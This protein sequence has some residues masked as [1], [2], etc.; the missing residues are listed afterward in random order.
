M[1]NMN[2]DNFGLVSG[3]LVSDP[4]ILSNSNGSRK[5]RLTLA[6]QNNYKDAN[7]ERG[8]QFLPLEAYIAPDKDPKVFT[9]MH[10]GDHIT[11]HYTVKN[12]NYTDKNTQQPVYGLTLQIEHVKLN[13]PKKVT[14]ERLAQRTVAGNAATDAEGAVTA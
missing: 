3:R 1:F 11:I 13:E 9:M 10:Q 2:V 6:A 14:E 7:N 8:A 5:V 12:N 4:Q